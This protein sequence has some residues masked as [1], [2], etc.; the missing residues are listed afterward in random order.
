[1]A[2]LYCSSSAFIF[3]S[4][5]SLYPCWLQNQPLAF[6]FTLSPSENMFSL[7]VSITKLMQMTPN[8][9]SLAL[10]LLWVARH[11]YSNALL[12]LQNHYFKIKWKF[13]LRPDSWPPIFPFCQW[14]CHSLSLPFQNLNVILKISP[15]PLYMQ[16]FSKSFPFQLLSTPLQSSSQCPSL[17]QHLTEPMHPHN[18]DTSTF[19]THFVVILLLQFVNLQWLYTAILLRK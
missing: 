13:I 14:L 16:S 12:P 7:M 10:T 8:S 4:D 19:S 2:S 5:S 3:M 9:V 18:A 17:T 11:L 15:F 1:M 6:L